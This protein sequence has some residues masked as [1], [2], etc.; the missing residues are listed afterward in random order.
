M[1]TREMVRALVGSGANGGLRRLMKDIPMRDQ[2]GNVLPDHPVD[3]VAKT[4]T[5]YFVSTLAGFARAPSGRDLAFAIFCGDL[6]RRGTFDTSQET[7]PPGAR[8][9]NGRAKQLQQALIERWAAVHG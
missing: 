9:Y 1:N 6:E 7:R 4:G 2:D 3:V 5:L 8:G